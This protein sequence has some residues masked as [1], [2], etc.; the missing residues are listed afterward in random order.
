[1]ATEKPPSGPWAPWEGRK[2]FKWEEIEPPIDLGTLEYLITEENLEYHRKAVEWPEAFQVTNEMKPVAMVMSARY[3]SEPGERH[4]NVR[5][6]IEYF[7]PMVPGKKILIS[8][9]L[10]DKYIKRDKPYIVLE[11][12]VWDEDGRHIE[13]YT[14]T[15]MTEAPK[16]GQ[17][18]WGKASKDT[19]IGTEVPP[20][21]K[22][23]TFDKMKFFEGLLPGKDA[24]THDSEEVAAQEGLGSPI[25]SAHHQISY[26]NEMLAKFFGPGWAK[27][28]KLDLKFIRP[29]V[30]GDTVTAKGIVRE[31]TEE[32]G[33]IRLGLEVWCENQKGE[34]T[35]VGTASGFVP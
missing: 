11:T 34:K 30:H 22:Y 3:Y 12:D 29:V 1:M 15:R 23:V 2:P 32:E 33:R 20:V 26:T 21:S 17:K 14:R 7:N 27:G 18:W 10:V 5:H 13:K 24:S 28:G 25:A 4:I 31:K 8:V 6:N 35:S 16:L 9:K 19:A